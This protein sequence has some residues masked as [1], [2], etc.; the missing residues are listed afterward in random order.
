LKVSI[1]SLSLEIREPWKWERRGYR[2][3]RDGRP[4]ENM[5]H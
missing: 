5:T 2:N 4:K 1:I 3:Q